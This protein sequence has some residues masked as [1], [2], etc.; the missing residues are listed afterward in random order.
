MNILLLFFY[1][2]F[3]GH[4]AYFADDPAKSHQFTNLDEALHVILYTR[5][6]MGKMFV[7]NGMPDPSTV[8]HSAKIGYH[9][10]KG[11]AQTPQPEYIVYRSAQALPYYKITY[12]HP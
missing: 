7:I 1:G 6:T 9:S 3:V 4:G 2:V 12:I 11:L 8:M 10:T 5:V